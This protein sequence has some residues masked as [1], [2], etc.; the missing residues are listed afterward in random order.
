MTLEERTAHRGSPD[1]MLEFARR[2]IDGRLAGFDKDMEICLTAKHREGRQPTHAYFPAL[3]ACCGTLE[4]L[5]GLSQ[6]ACT[7]PRG[8]DKV[9]DWCEKFMPQPEYNRETIRVLFRVFR[10]PVAHRGIASGVWVDTDKDPKRHG[11]RMTWKV[12]AG[13]QGP[14]CEIRAEVG[15]LRCDSPWDCP[16]THRVRIDLRRLWRDVCRGAEQYKSA[17]SEDAGLLKKFEACMHQLYP[18][19]KGNKA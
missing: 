16:Y 5:T 8:W 6:G 17:L 14:G 13:G 1:D 9:A 4:Y 19:P 18:V 11:R 12:L 7:Q 15:Q 3:A 2:F 10:N